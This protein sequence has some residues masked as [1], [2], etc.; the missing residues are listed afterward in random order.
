MS[1]KITTELIQTILAIIAIIVGGMWTYTLFVLER[2]YVR[3]IQLDFEVKSYKLT[4]NVNLLVVSV[5][6]ENNKKVK[7]SIDSRV[8]RIQQISPILP[9]AEGVPCWI[10]QINQSFKSLSRTENGYTWPMIYKRE[11]HLEH[12][13]QFDPGEKGAIT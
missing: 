6:V 2:Q 1:I 9:C 11:M 13:Y 7:A 5:L 4:D 12:P 8:I 3:G 10:D